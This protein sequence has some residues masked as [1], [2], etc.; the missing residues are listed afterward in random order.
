MV[1]A[2]T[3]PRTAAH[4]HHGEAY[5][6]DAAGGIEGQ[7]AVRQAVHLAGGGLA[8]RDDGRAADRTG[9]VPEPLAIGELEALKA[10]LLGCAAR[11][12]NTAADLVS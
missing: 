4:L 7:P 2:V 6:V 10:E 9:T 11:L 12:G 8:A 3:D 1:H 5:L